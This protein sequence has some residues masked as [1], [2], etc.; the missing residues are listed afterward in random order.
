MVSDGSFS[1]SP[2]ALALIRYTNFSLFNAMIIPS[3]PHRTTK[4]CEKLPKEVKGNVYS[5]RPIENSCPFCSTNFLWPRLPLA[6]SFLF[7]AEPRATGEFVCV[8]AAH[9]SFSFQ[10]CVQYCYEFERKK[11]P[12]RNERPDKWKQFRLNTIEMGIKAVVRCLLAERRIASQIVHPFSNQTGINVASWILL[13][14]VHRTSMRMHKLCKEKNPYCFRCRLCVRRCR[15]HT[16]ARFFSVV[17]VFFLS[18]SCFSLPS[19]SSLSIFF[20]LLR[21]IAASCAYNV[22]IVFYMPLHN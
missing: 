2:A 4:M 16:F 11:N 13:L 9:I 6:F 18:F 15:R 10:F 14:A 12:K 22:C 7:V 19:S 20:L 21:L 3:L 1:I 5:C 8:N 17:S